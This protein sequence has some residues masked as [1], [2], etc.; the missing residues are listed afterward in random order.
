[1]PEVCLSSR[2]AYAFASSGFKIRNGED[3]APPFGKT[4][5]D[6]FRRTLAYAWGAA[7]CRWLLPLLLL[8]FS[9]QASG[10]ATKTLRNALVDPDRRSLSAVAP[11]W[12]GRSGIERCVCHLRTKFAGHGS[13]L[14]DPLFLSLPSRKSKSH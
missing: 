2:T 3:V 13:A 1:M 4:S 7:C 14:P 12:G 8:E 9:L 6:G 10:L 5:P 11:T